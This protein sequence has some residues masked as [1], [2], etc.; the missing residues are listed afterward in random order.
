[1]SSHGG[2]GDRWLVSY[3][4]FMTLLMVMFVVL[5]SMSETDLAKYKVMAEG[6]RSAFGGGGPVNIVDPEIK[7]GSGTNNDSAPIVIPGLPL[8]SSVGVEVADDLT[9]M[10]TNQ[11]LGS[12]VSIQNNIEGILISLSEKL[13]FQEGTAELQPEALP[14]LD[15]IVEMIKP[16]ENDV[17]IVGHTDDSVPTD[18]R[19]SDN[20]QLSLARAFTITEYFIDRGVPAYRLIPSGRGD[21]QPIFPNDTPQ[22]RA[23]NGRADIV[24][25]YSI[26][27]DVMDLESI[28]G[29]SN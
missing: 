10:L 19:F 23:L 25:V 15:K 1:M 24:I 14:I 4:D 8:S 26:S 11:D 28:I 22:H 12:E 6:F 29:K 20:W 17:R 27:M 13:L 18:P 21:T 3:A 7:T 16:I 9:S 5:W 2:G